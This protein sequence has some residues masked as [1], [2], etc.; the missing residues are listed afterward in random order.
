MDKPKIMGKSDGTFIGQ[1]PTQLPVQKT[2]I[3]KA[4]DHSITRTRNKKQKRKY[5][6]QRINKLLRAATRSQ[7]TASIPR[8]LLEM[9]GREAL[10]KAKD[11]T[12][13]RWF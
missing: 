1:P 13:L 12:K 5:A 4:D 10:K 3:I 11:K 6:M 9:G 7:T 8:D 2:P